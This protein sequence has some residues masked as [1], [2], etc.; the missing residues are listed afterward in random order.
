MKYKWTPII[1]VGSVKFTQPTNIVL[2]SEN[3]KNGHPSN[4]GSKTTDKWLIFKDLH[5]LS[6]LAYHYY[7]I[8]MNILKHWLCC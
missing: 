5:L 4:I 3:S 2:G 8:Q 1:L 7:R 6:S